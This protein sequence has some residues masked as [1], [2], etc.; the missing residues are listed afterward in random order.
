RAGHRLSWELRRVRH[1]RLI[2]RSHHL[3]TCLHHSC[4]PMKELCLHLLHHHKKA[5]SAL[6][7]MGRLRMTASNVLTSHRHLHHKKV[8]DGRI[9]LPL[10]T[11]V[12]NEPMGLDH[13]TE[14]ACYT[15][16]RRHNS[17]P[18]G[19]HHNSELAGCLTDRKA[20]AVGPADTARCLRLNSLRGQML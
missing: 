11:K 16:R 15:I 13:K 5:S 14:L 17:E 3:T 10:R 9:P 18:V 2:R 4:R 8:P 7:R 1:R 6:M 12:W 19:L 20:K